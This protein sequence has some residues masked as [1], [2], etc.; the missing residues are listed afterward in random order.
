MLV[1][2]NKC[3]TTASF[4]SLAKL[5]NDCNRHITSEHE[6]LANSI[7]LMGTMRNT[8]IEV[9]F[10]FKGTLSQWHAAAQTLHRWQLLHLKLYQKLSFSDVMAIFN[11]VCKT[12]VSLHWWWLA[13]QLLIKC[14]IHL[15]NWAIKVLLCE[16]P[17]AALF[18]ACQLCCRRVGHFCETGP[19]EWSLGSSQLPQSLLSGFGSK[20]REEGPSWYGC[21]ASRD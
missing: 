20:W 3:N 4:C 11:V 1:W 12:V 5:Q 9:F 8:E 15:S 16:H 14:S 13:L 6:K 19:I 21:S 17:L 2:V 10:C 18:R 7:D